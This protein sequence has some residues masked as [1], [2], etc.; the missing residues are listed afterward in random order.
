MTVISNTRNRAIFASDNVAS[1]H[2]I[3]LNAFA[4]AAGHPN[5]P[6]GTG[7]YTAELNAYLRELFDRQFVRGF[8]VATGTFAN[9]VG[10]GAMLDAGDAVVCHPLSHIVTE[11]RAALNAK[12]GAANNFAS[13]PHAKIDF[14]LLQ[15]QLGFKTDIHQCRRRVLT[16]TQCTERGT[17][18]K[19]DEFCRI[20]KLAKQHNL[21][22]HIDGARM[23]N[24]IASEGSSLS[25]GLNDQ[26]WFADAVSL[27]FIKSGGLAADLLV[28]FDEQL[29]KRV[30]VSLKSAGH[31]Y[32][33]SECHASQILS[34][35]DSG[36]W[37]E[38]GRTS[39]KMARKLEVELEALG[40]E[41]AAPVESNGVFVNL[42]PGTRKSLQSNGWIFRSYE[43]GSSR[44]MTHW[45]TNDDDIELLC[46]HVQRSLIC[47]KVSPS[48]ISVVDGTIAGERNPQQCKTKIAINIS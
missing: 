19:H 29:A 21:R 15:D 36:A 22:V 34:L 47:D 16:I 10:I 26:T 7:K 11:E 17:T 42:P 25:S 46:S 44:F 9:V 18:Y 27:G 24:A 48:G 6:Y 14:R 32:S 1:A 3:G 35:M 13:G 23:I 8:S 20:A 30:E 37:L 33:K 28:V 2:P 5:T 43:D 31:L 4:K 38:C 39:N 45:Q 41:I 40:V 12:F